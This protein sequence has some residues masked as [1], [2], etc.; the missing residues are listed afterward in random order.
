MNTEIKILKS[1]Q[2][3][4]EAINKVKETKQSIK[5]SH[6]YNTSE[7]EMGK[8]NMTGVDI[9]NGDECDEIKILE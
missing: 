7:E 9:I 3:F 8:L 4:Q 6:D 5:V 2:E 1:I